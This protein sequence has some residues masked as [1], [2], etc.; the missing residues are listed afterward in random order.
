MK[1]W[2]IDVKITVIATGLGEQRLQKQEEKYLGSDFNKRTEQAAPIATEAPA[3]AAPVEQEVSIQ[4]SAPVVAA[5]I[6]PVIEEPIV[7]AAPSNFESFMEEPAT[8]SYEEE[9]ATEP[10]S[11]VRS[12]LAD[13][14][15]KAASNYEAAKEMDNATVDRAERIEEK[16]T[17]PAPKEKSRAQAIAEKLGFMNFDEDEFDSPSYLR[18]DAQE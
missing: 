13:S 5:P 16:A 15:R 11:E 17:A 8:P 2:V 18:K 10:T 14:I 6:E 3:A 7:E 1:I 12:R 4:R 9:Q